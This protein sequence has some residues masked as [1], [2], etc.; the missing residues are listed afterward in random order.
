ME[1]TH[2]QFTQ[3]DCLPPQRGNVSLS[4]L[5]MLNAISYVAEHGCKWRGLPKRFGKWRTIYP[6]MNRW[7]GV[8]DRVFEEL[9][10]SKA[11]RIKI[12]SCRWTAPASRC[13]RMA[14]ARKPS[15]NPKAEETPR[16]TWLP[17]M[18][19]RP[20]VL[21]IDGHAGLPEGARCC[22]GW[23]RRTDRCLCSRTAPMKAYDV[24]QGGG[25]IP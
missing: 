21:T 1:I 12:K 15:A 18:L 5:N 13:I 7:S 20:Y 23:A 3:I 11:M 4:N 25:R 14:L 2:A 10:Q 22:F 17:R 16:F 24:R 6:R 9:R 8:M 19:A